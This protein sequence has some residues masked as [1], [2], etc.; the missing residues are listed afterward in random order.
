MWGPGGALNCV[1]Y[2]GDKAQYRAAAETKLQDEAMTESV[3]ESCCICLD[4][5][6][7][8]AR[9]TLSCG[10]LL[11]ESCVREMRRLGASGSCPLCPDRR[12]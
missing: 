5:L 3:E 9:Q 2:V 4:S 11:H 12:R 10:H 7:T 6:N 1:Y 8:G